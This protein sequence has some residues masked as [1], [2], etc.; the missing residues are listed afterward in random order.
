MSL[1]GLYG[2][3]NSGK[4]TIAKCL[5]EEYG[6]IELSF[7]APLKDIVSIIYGFDRDMLEGD[8]NEKRKKKE[9]IKDPIWGRTARSAL[10]YVGTEVFRNHHDKDTW[11]LICKR[12]IVEH[13]SKGD[14]IV[15]SD[16]R[17]PNEADMIRG[18][19]G[20]L[21]KIHRTNLISKDFHIS[22]TAMNDYRYDEIFYND[23]FIVDIPKKIKEL[24]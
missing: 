7:A 10:Q 17:F 11:A 19:G 3:K 23:E 1:I 21:W 20:K 8:T 13:L 9:T 14:N 12:K 16:V 24:L 18:L 4:S 6:Y 15:V 5:S 22:E 2:Y